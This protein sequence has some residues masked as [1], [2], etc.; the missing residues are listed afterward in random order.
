MNRITILVL[1]IVLITGTLATAADQAKVPLGAI[2]SDCFEE[3][4]MAKTEFN[5]SDLR[6][7]CARNEWLASKRVVEPLDISGLVS[8]WPME[9]GESKTIKSRDNGGQTGKLIGTSWVKGSQGFGLYFDGQ[10]SYGEIGVSFEALSDWTISLWLTVEK[11]PLKTRQFYCQF[12]G[13]NPNAGEKG[14]IHFSLET[15]DGR[16]RFVIWGGPGIGGNLSY[17][18]PDTWQQGQWH[19]IAI[20]QVNNENKRY[21]YVDGEL[22]TSDENKDINNLTELK[23]ISQPAAPWLGSLDEFRVYN[24]ALTAE[25]IEK[26]YRKTK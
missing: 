19:H 10:E 26:V 14:P 8:Y 3:I 11:L 17:Q 6:W 9:K 7:G 20:K 5:L 25:E 24:R 12:G 1:M 13:V 15:D 4:D 23:F 16:P 21:F 18:V 22:V 2:K